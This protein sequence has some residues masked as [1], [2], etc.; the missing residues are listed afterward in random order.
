MPLVTLTVPSDIAGSKCDEVE[1]RIIEILRR[2][3]IEGGITVW[4]TM[5]A[6]V[7]GRLFLRYESRQ[8]LNMEPKLLASLLGEHVHQVLGYQVESVVVKLDPKTTGI[9]ITE[10]TTAHTKKSDC[11]VCGGPCIGADA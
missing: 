11:D 2:T 5:L 1:Q 6:K 8:E 3:G 4:Q 9:H 7:P 10:A